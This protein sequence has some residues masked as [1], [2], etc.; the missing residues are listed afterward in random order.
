VKT[1]G[2]SSNPTWRYITATYTNNGNLRLYVDSTLQDTS[3]NVVTGDVST[4]A[5]AH[6]IVIGSS[7]D[8]NYR[9]TQVVDDVKWYNRPLELSEIKKNYKATKSRHSSTS[10]WSDDFSSDFI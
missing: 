1:L 4:T 5:E 6:P 9:S 7:K 8:Y 10:S 2:T 3:D